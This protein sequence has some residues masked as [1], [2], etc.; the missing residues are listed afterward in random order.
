[1]SRDDPLAPLLE[2]IE[3]EQRKKEISSRIAKVSLAW[4]MILL[5]I[6]WVSKYAYRLI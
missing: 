6:G 5:M 1:M 4:F 3:K 2:E